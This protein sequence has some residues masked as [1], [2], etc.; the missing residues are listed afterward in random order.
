MEN[1][2]KN[3]IKEINLY[4]YKQIIDGNFKLLYE[5][6]KRDGFECKIEIEGL[7][8]TMNVFNKGGI[9]LHEESNY[10]FNMDNL[11]EKV[12]FDRKS[13]SEILKTR[14]IKVKIEDL[15]LEKFRLTKEIKKIEGKIKNIDNQTKSLRRNE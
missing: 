12:C 7:I 11:P 10:I 14:N 13:I 9:Y 15:E 2:I 1:T 6:N 8:F 4:T 3:Q 5:E